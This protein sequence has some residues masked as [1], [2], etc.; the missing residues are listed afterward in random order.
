VYC[1]LWINFHSIL[2]HT[3][4]I[5][6]SCEDKIVEVAVSEL[7]S[8][9]VDPESEQARGPNPSYIQQIKCGLRKIQLYLSDYYRTL[10][11][12]ELERP[13]SLSGDDDLYNVTVT[14]HVLLITLFII[15]FTF[16][17]GFRT[18]LV[19]LCQEKMVQNFAKCK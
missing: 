13:T 12:A 6:I 14:I 18:R 9:E 4:S 8:G 16:I 10:I 2:C 5:R 17:Q 3:G 15:T 11:C 1:I 7:R 19:T